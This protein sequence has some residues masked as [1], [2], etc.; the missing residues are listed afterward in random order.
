MERDIKIEAKIK[1]VKYTPF[2][3]KNLREY[4]FDNLEKG[5]SEGTFILNHVDKKVAVSRWVSSKRTRSYPYARVYDSLSF[6]GKRITIIPI[7]KDEGKDGDRDYLQWDTISLMS[8]LGVYVII[9][10]YKDAEKNINYNNKITNQKYDVDQIKNEIIKIFSYQSDALHWNISQVENIE[11][12][13]KKALHSYKEISKK[14]NLQMH[15]E[16]SAKSR[17][18]KI[19]KDKDSFMALSRDLAKAAQNRESLTLQPKES[20][21]GE[22]GKITIKNYLGGNYYFTA[23][24]VEIE[25]N[26]VNLIEAKHSSSNIIPSLEDIKDGLIKM[27]LFTNL[28]N[29]KVNGKDYVPKAVL[30]LT[31][32]QKF[33]TTQM[34]KT[35]KENYEL[36]MKESKINGF[37]VRI[38]DSSNKKSIT[39]DPFLK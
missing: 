11:A 13:G 37:Q 14:L 3:C 25:S 10:Y 31:T 27:I 23:D 6:S 21:E 29:V 20:I 15:G 12:V 7:I 28:E 16:D 34:S 9:S 1:E 8:L 4:N 35:Q 39:L 33:D 38:G 22:K 17:I 24:E 26:T 36:L 30:K 2:L 32:K 18:E 5:L 19:S